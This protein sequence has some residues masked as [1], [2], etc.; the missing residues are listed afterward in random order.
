MRQ[1]TEHFVEELLKSCLKN[2]GVLDICRAHLQFQ[3]LSD[4][5]QKKVWQAIAHHADVTGTAP[6]IGALGEKFHHDRKVMEVLAGIKAADLPDN[7]AVLFSLESY[8]KQAMFVELYDKMGDLWNAQKQDEALAYVEKRSLEINGFSVK[9]KAFV[10]V[11]GNY[12]E[13]LKTKLLRKGEPSSL[14]KATTGIPELDADM[15]G[16]LME[17]D[18]FCW[19]ARSGIGKTKAMR[20]SAVQNARRGLRV[21]HVSLEGTEQKAIDGMDATWHGVSTAAVEACDFSEKRIAEFERAARTVPGEIHVQAYEQFGQASMADVRQML[22]DCEKAHGKVDLLQMDYL[23]KARPANNIKYSPDQER[24]RRAAIADDF[25]NL[26]TE[27][28]TRGI[29]A[30]QAEGVRMDKWNKSDFVLTRENVSECKA[31]V[32][33]FSFFVSMNQTIEEKENAYMR[34]H[35]DKFRDYVGGRTLGIYQSYGT[36]RFYDHQT[37]T[38]NLA[39]ITA[40]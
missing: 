27:A 39:A 10:N 34:L 11:F 28:K 12:S 23:E 29:V 4:E 9:G 8:L 31:L 25:K 15:G 1:L 26:C 18:T 40:L 3:Y 35:Q 7:E 2:R 6:S 33:S 17:G 19:L 32:N 14:I 5:G 20:W 36:E 22:Y 24:H 21:L 13:R 37:T 30:T 38:N 16:G